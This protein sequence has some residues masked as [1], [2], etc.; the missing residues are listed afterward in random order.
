MPEIRSF[1]AG[2]AD[3]PMAAADI[4]HHT[5]VWGH[6]RTPKLTFVVF[7]LHAMTNAFHA[8]ADGNLS[9]M[10]GQAAGLWRDIAAA[11]RL[12]QDL[13]DSRG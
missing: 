2:R 10:G 12:A 9:Q 1:E 13:E 5:Q 11:K 4:A 6:H 7:R 3:G 8:A